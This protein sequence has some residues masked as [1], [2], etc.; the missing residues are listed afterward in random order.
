MMVWAEIPDEERYP[1]LKAKVLKH[2]IHSPCGDSSQRYPCTGNDGKCSKG[3]PKE[4][5]DETNANVNEYPMY[6]QK[7]TGKKYIVRNKKINNQWLVPYSPY[8]IM[9]YDRHTNLEICSSVKSVKYLYK[10]FDWASTKMQSRDSTRLIKIDEVN[11][12]LDA[13]YVRAPKAMWRLNG[14][15]LFMKSHTVIRLAIHLPNRHMVYF[16][17]GNKE[18]AVQKEFTRYYADCMVQIESI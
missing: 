7:N 13:K 10:E 12:F 8:L 16:R 15:D 11:S 17:A 1:E 6:Q 4:F 3:F 2:M 9:K 14:Y 5:R 18:Q